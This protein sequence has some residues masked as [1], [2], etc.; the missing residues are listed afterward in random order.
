MLKAY[1]RVFV[2]VF[3][4]MPVILGAQERLLVSYAG[5][6]KSR[7]LPGLLKTWGFLPSMA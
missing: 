5:F 7:H 2:F 3:S 1:S 6:S 4:A